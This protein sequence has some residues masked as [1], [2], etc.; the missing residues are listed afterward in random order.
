[1]VSGRSIVTELTLTL[2]NS[3][4]FC[5]CVCTVNVCVYIVGSFY[6]SRLIYDIFEGL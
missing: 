1:M 5:V 4:E 3:I 6:S 2:F